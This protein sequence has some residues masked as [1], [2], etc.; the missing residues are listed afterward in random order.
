MLI[1][2]TL[3]SSYKKL[4]L[5]PTAHEQKNEICKQVKDYEFQA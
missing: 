1:F 3:Q 5:P 4:F 2:L